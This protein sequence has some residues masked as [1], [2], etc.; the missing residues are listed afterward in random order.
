MDPEV[1][2]LVAALVLFAVCLERPPA[3]VPAASR[4]GALDS[5]RLYESVSAVRIERVN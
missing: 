2:K 3:P 1:A 5:S 4:R